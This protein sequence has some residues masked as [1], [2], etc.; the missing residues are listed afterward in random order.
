MGHVAA[1][2]TLQGWHETLC[3]RL[4]NMSLL[5]NQKL[6]QSETTTRI[7]CARAHTG[8]NKMAA[9]SSG[10]RAA[11]FDWN[12][13]H[14]KR[15]LRVIFMMTDHDDFFFLDDDFVLVFCLL[16]LSFSCLSHRTGLSLK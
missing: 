8:K 10:A 11:A 13:L 5:Q 14:R 1:T 12:D 2:K 15:K 7:L 16:A 3:V 6:N 9:I 4:C